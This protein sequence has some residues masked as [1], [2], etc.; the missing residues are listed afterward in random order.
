MSWGTKKY[1]ESLHRTYGVPLP[2]RDDAAFARALEFRERE[3]AY[4]RGLGDE[5]EFLR[6]LVKDKTEEISRMRTASMMLADYY[7]ETSSKQYAKH[8]EEASGRTPT[9][10][11]DLRVP[12]PNE[13]QQQR[14]EREPDKRRDD[15]VPGKVLPTELPDPGGPVGQHAGDGPEPGSG[16]ADGAESA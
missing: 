9:V 6:E 2:G 16:S 5:N 7:K 3:K 10:A 1:I 8:A 14:A 12:E 11:G 4:Y 13:Q 15:G